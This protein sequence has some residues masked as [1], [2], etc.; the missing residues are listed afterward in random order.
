[1][2][3]HEMVSKRAER[4]MLCS[5]R[6]SEDWKLPQKVWMRDLQLSKVWTLMAMKCSY[7][8]R[9]TGSSHRT[10]ETMT[11]QLNMPRPEKE[12]HGSGPTM[13]RCRSMCSCST[14]HVF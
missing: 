14:V 1:M 2:V 10:S 6:V 3:N 12:L 11:N 4:S 9:A 5:V 7:R 13:L 8:I